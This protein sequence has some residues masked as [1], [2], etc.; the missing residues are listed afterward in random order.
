MKRKTL[1]RKQMP[2]PPLDTLASNIIMH[3]HSSDSPHHTP[4]GRIER[5]RQRRRHRLG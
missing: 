2:L 4:A 1:K 3:T 5:W